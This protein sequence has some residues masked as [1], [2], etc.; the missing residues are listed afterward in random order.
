MSVRNLIYPALF[1]A[2]VVFTGVGYS[3]FNWASDRIVVRQA[4]ETSQEWG[5]Y[6]G[7]ELDR[8][9]VIASGEKL[10][11]DEQAFLTKVSQFGNV[12]RF[13]LFDSQ[14]R[15]R[16]TSDDLANPDTNQIVLSEQNPKAASVITTGQPHTTLNDG[17][18]N[19]I[20]QIFMP[21]AMSR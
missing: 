10:T 6:I 1:L 13:K 4:Q 7:A 2:L 3:L 18:Q 9:E 8:I 17:T 14:G 11:I 16:L 15:L 20:G 5:D 19:L 21:K 12:F